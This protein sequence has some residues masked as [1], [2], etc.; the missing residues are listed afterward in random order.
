VPFTPAVCD[1]VIRSLNLPLAQA[2]AVP[3][4]DSPPE[5]AKQL[6]PA[7]QVELPIAPPLQAV[8]EAR[9]EPVFNTRGDTAVNPAKIDATPALGHTPVENET[10]TADSTA[11]APEPALAAKPRFFTWLKRLFNN[12]P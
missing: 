7:A 11:P 4:A 8:P 12:S 9:A 5:P 6:R 10:V 1:F 2:P 3:P